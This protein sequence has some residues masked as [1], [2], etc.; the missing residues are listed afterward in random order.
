MQEEDNKKQQEEEEEK[1]LIL[2]EDILK[3]IYSNTRISL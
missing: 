3:L 1:N 2:R